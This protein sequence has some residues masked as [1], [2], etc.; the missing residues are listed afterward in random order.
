[1]N[2]LEINGL[3][4]SYDGAVFALKDCNFNLEKGKICAVVG[5]SGSGKS[6]LIRLIAGLE[7]PEKGTIKIL[8]KTV[9][10]ESIIEDPQDR[11][12]GL[13]FQDLAL[14]PHLTVAQNISFGLKEN[15]KEKVKQLLEVIQLEGYEKQY[16]SQLSGGQE[17]RV[18][19]ARTLAL[20]PELLLLDEPFSS[21]D[22]GLKSDLRNQV[23]NIVNNLGTSMMFITH[24]IMDA[25]DIADVILFIKNGKIVAKS[26]VN[27]LKSTLHKPEV[28]EL[29]Q[30]LIDNSK[31]IT[32]LLG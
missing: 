12:V 28:Q 29:F 20:E 19:I 11:N 1:M 10:S 15:K 24:D 6:T 16:P 21:L 8:G 18:A 2:V 13:V 17:Q 22:A 4:K 9:S 3:S 14:F 23:K 31:K 30:D 26:T 5:E 32:E 27:E 7:R 25:I